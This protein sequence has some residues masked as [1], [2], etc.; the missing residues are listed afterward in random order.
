MRKR[1]LLLFCSLSCLVMPGGLLALYFLAP[2]E[3]T[4]ANMNKVTSDMTKQEMIALLGPPTE[5]FGPY[6]DGHTGER[7]QGDNCELR[8]RFD[9]NGRLY[10]SSLGRTTPSRLIN[11]VRLWFE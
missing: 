9:E 1:V 11:K 6:W 8:T 7:W 4:W 3:P 10:W 5:S 2:V